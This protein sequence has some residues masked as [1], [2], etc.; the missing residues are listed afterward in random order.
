MASFR[1]RTAP[2]V[3]PSAREADALSCREDGQQTQRIGECERYA[4]GRVY[5]FAGDG[6]G[7]RL[8]YRLDR[9]MLFDDVPVLLEDEQEGALLESDHA[10]RAQTLTAE[11]GELDC[12]EQAPTRIVNAASPFIFV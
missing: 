7:Q 10:A 9:S 6:P 8:V 12:G 11:F 4:T 5:L 3:V 1:T 2:T